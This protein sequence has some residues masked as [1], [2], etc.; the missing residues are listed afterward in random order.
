MF[1]YIDWTQGHL[2][3]YWKLNMCSAVLGN[4]QGNCTYTHWGGN[5]KQFLYRWTDTKKEEPQP[6]HA[7]ESEKCGLSSQ[8]TGYKKVRKES[9]QIFQVVIMAHF[10]EKGPIKN[11]IK[12]M[13]LVLL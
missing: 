6:K 2:S 4:A 7:L 5:K 13:E 11:T 8:K 9:L 12:D 3:V 1:A 10:T